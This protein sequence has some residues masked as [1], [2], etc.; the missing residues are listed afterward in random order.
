[1]TGSEFV[2]RYFGCSHLTASSASLTCFS[3]SIFFADPRMQLVPTNAFVEALL[4]AFQHLGN[5]FDTTLQSTKITDDS[6]IIPM[7]PAGE[8]F[9]ASFICIHQC[10]CVFSCS[11]ST[12]AL[13]VLFARSFGACSLACEL[14]RVL[15]LPLILMEVWNVSDY[16]ANRHI[17]D[18]GHLC[19]SDG[20][21]PVVPASIRNLSSFSDRSY[22]PNKRAFIGVHGSWAPAPPE[23]SREQ[24]ARWQSQLYP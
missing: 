12:C 19:P 8:L 11:R 21:R 1:M 6:S 4:A 5:D 10:L 9:E 22:R 24:Q 3:V 20:R 13:C 14:Q 7:I 17:P 15:F 23:P 18:D 2:E 16:K